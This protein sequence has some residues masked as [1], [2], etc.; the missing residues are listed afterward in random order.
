MGR[1][2]TKTENT[3]STTEAPQITSL[4]VLV[5]RLF[6]TFLGPILLFGAGYS[7][8]SHRGWFTPWDAFFGVVVILMIMA[9]WIEQR[10]GTGATL[11]GRKSTPTDFHRF[12]FVL[13]A[14]S[15]VIWLGANVFSNVLRG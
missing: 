14:A 1:N 7:V 10:S 3:N 9:R 8:G 6:W 13:V 11:S 4:F 2:T 5:A 12:E 15:A